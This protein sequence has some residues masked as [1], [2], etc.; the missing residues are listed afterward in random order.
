VLAVCSGKGGVGKSRVAL[1]LAAALAAD[2]PRVGL[3]DADVHAPDIPLMVGL[4]RRVRTKSWTL[5]RVGGLARTK[6]EPV[7]CFGLRLMSTGFIVGEDQAVAWTADLVGVLLSQLLWATQ[8]GELDYLVIDLP[9]G[10]SDITQE[11]MRLLPGAAAVLVVT[12]Q[13]VAHLDTRRLLTALGT[14]GVRILGGI[15]N[16]SHLV[17]PC[18]AHRIEVFP[19]VSEERSIWAGGLDRLGQVP[20]EPGGGAEPV[21]LTGPETGRGAALRAA[22][23]AIRAMLDGDGPAGDSR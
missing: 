10:T 20:L 17:C 4:A 11:I 6:L 16:M 5:S 21:V 23:A 3:L 22:A 18:C 2:G 13:D 9:P 1:N 8:W 14:G 12:P 7:D 19:A 15:E